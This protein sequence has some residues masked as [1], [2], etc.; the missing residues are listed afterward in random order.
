MKYKYPITCLSALLSVA[1]S[2]CAANI[3]FEYDEAGNRI[4]RKTIIFTTRSAAVIDTT[5][6]EEI[7]EPEP[8]VVFT[9]IP[10]ESAILIYPNPTKGLLKVEISS[11]G[12]ITPVAL[13]L[14]DMAGKLL[15]EESNVTSSATFDLGRQSPGTYILRLFSGT[16]TS[17]WKV[18]KE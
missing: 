8:P 15:Q 4:S 12:E 17:E 14:Y 18:I 6:E 1:G 3:Q 11:T 5:A 7:E 9:G 10:A 13:Q 16:Q 2:L